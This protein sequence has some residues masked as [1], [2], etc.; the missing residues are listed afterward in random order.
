MQLE[1]SGDLLT[2]SV[3]H[4][5]EKEDKGEGE[6]RAHRIERTRMSASRSV[7][8]P[9]RAQLDSV[10]ASYKDGVLTLDIAKVPEDKPGKKKIAIN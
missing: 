9:P 2:I 6:E 1:T 3:E 10:S 8:M 5:E 7:T 4:T